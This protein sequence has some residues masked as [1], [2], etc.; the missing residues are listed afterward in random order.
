MGLTLV[1]G[2]TRSGK[3]AHAEALA[4]ASGLPVRYVATADPGDGSMTARIAAHAARRPAEWETVVAGDDLASLVTPG[5]CVLI[6]GLGAWIAAVMHRSDAEI[7]EMPSATASDP[8]R[9]RVRDE[10][11]ASRSPRRR[12]R[13]P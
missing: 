2:G 8:S 12:P 11:A 7:D 5:R 6:D 3:S 4:R 1:L 13:A 9:S 10:V